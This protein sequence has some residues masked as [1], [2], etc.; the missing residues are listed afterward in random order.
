M[1]PFTPFVNEESFTEFFCQSP[2]PGGDQLLFRT[3]AATGKRALAEGFGSLCLLL[4][5]VPPAVPNFIASQREKQK[6]SHL[7]RTAISATKTPPVCSMRCFRLS[8]VSRDQRESHVYQKNLKII[9]K[10]KASSNVSNQGNE[11]CGDIAAYF[12]EIFFPVIIGVFWCRRNLRRVFTVHFLRILVCHSPYS[13]CQC[14]CSF[15]LW[16]GR[17]PDG[18]PLANH[19]S[20]WAALPTLP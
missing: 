2:E 15:Q 12:L 17:S 19:R 20:S 16:D 7:L 9:K 6:L 14:K 1:G 4:R 5:C 13:D 18:C 3:P 10:S 11:I 8:H